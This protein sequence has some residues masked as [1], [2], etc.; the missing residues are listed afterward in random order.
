MSITVYNTVVKLYVSCRRYVLTKAIKELILEFSAPEEPF[1]GCLNEWRTH[2]QRPPPPP[3]KPGLLFIQWQSCRCSRQKVFTSLDPPAFRELFSA[4]DLAL[5][6]VKAMAQAIDRAM[7]N[8]VILKGHLWLNLTEINYVKASFLESPVS[9]TG[10]FGSLMVWT[11]L[12]PISHPKLC[13][14]S[15][16]SGPA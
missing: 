1:C 15:C 2:C 16:L 7:A 5:H 11:S 13:A 10:L 8:L 6:T 12:Q 3:I 4:T 14:T 9:P